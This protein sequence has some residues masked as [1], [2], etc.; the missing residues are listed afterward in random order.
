MEETFDEQWGIWRWD[1]NEYAGPIKSSWPQM[2]LQQGWF[3]LVAGPLTEPVR[4]ASLVES[5]EEILYLRGSQHGWALTVSQLSALTETSIFLSVSETLSCIS[6][7]ILGLWVLQFER[8]QQVHLPSYLPQSFLIYCS[9]FPR[10]L[11]VSWTM[12]WEAQYWAHLNVPQREKMYWGC[13]FWWLWICN[14]LEFGGFKKFLLG[15]PPLPFK[16]RRGRKKKKKPWKVSKLNLCLF[17]LRN[18]GK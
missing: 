14:I 8:P 7:T 2:A 9:G 10:K 16:K 1:G 3:M 13:R 6:Y 5:R 15:F 18:S 12:P 11:A 4:C 17:L